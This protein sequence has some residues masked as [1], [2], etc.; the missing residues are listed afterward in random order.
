[1]SSDSSDSG[2]D[3]K[4]YKLRSRRYFPIWRQKTLASAFSKGFEEYL[5]KDKTVKTQNE[6]DTQE[7]SY[8]NETDDA[9]RRK[10]KG[11]LMK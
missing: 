6:I 5:L 8:I 4:V 10:T 11:E 1:M 3:S 7:M 2:Q 9:K